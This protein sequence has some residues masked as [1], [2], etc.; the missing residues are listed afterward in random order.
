MKRPGLPAYKYPGAWGTGRNH[1][2]N[3]VEGGG[4]GGN[5]SGGRSSGRTSGDEFEVSDLLLLISAEW[6][7]GRGGPHTICMN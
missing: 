7:G 6:G 5:G 3:V 2:L 4:G 1:V